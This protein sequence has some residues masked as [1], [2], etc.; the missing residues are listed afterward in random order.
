M[1][2][3]GM[4]GIQAAALYVAG[5]WA[6]YGQKDAGFKKDEEKG[7][8]MVVSRKNLTGATAKEKT[9][10]VKQMRQGRV[11]DL[12]AAALKRP[13]A[14]AESVKARYGKAY[15]AGGEFYKGYVKQTFAR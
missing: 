5:V 4:H 9:E 11:R 12:A 6:L 8:L 1:A 2:I 15:E 13:G 10:A 14:T 3:F 7:T